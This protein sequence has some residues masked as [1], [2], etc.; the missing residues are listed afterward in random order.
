M[1][2]VSILAVVFLILWLRER[3]IGRRLRQEN[4]EM[5]RALG[6]M[7]EVAPDR[8]A[9]S[10]RDAIDNRELEELRERIQVLERIATDNNSSEASRARAIAAEIESL[11]GDIADRRAGRNT[12][13][14]DR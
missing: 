8:P 13:D 12:E 14:M 1:S 10:R 2:W 11:R 3:N 5:Q 9:Q 6:P 7:V 4:E